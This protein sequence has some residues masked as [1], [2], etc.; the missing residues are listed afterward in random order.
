MRAVVVHFARDLL[1]LALVVLAFAL[2][3][4][5]TKTV[6]RHQCERT[7]EFAPKIANFYEAHHV[8]NGKT[9]EDYRATI[10]KHC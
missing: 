5:S 10:P 1:L 7:R 3:F 6:T 4:G 8:L 2:I 9:L